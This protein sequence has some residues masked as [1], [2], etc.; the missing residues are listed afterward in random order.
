MNKML[1]I[2]SLPA[3]LLFLLYF[4]LVVIGGGIV[5]VFWCGQHWHDK[6]IGKQF[7]IVNCGGT[8]ITHERIH[9]D[10]IP[11]MATEREKYSGMLVTW[12]EPYDPDATRIAEMTARIKH[13][14]TLFELLS[15]LTYKE[16]KQRVKLLQ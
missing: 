14:E 12:V 1:Q 13:L 6:H 8:L 3:D 5:F 16:F 4:G 7:T 11:E 15:K 10:E 2:D 9:N